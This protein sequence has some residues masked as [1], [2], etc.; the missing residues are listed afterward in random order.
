MRSE[1][2]GCNAQSQ[3]GHLL[4]VVWLKCLMILSDMLEGVMSYNH[5]NQQRSSVQT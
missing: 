1:S 3:L 2:A 4:Q 5:R